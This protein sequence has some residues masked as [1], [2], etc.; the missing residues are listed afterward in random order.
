MDVCRQ[1]DCFLGDLRFIELGG[2][3]EDEGKV[4]QEFME[5]PVAGLALVS[6][7]CDIARSCADRPS[8]EVCPLVLIEDSAF[9]AQIVAR[10]RPGMQ[11]SRV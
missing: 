4:T 5:T 1:G 9:Y 8:V 6:Q 3:L 11:P 10:K 7:S 2:S